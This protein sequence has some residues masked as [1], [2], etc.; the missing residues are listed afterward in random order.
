MTVVNNTNYLIFTLL[1]IA[2]CALH[3]AMIT[4]YFTQHV[5]QHLAHYSRYH[6]LF[7]NIVS[8]LTLVP[9]IFYQTTLTTEAIFDWRGIFR[10]PQLIFVSTGV[11]LFYLGMKKYDFKRFFGVSQ[12]SELTATKGITQSGGL[13]TTGILNV[14]RHPWYTGFILVLWARPIDTSNLI[15]NT[16]FTVICI[17]ERCSKKENSL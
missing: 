2:W 4:V 3:S 15:L 14:I 16:V 6:R 10:I 8:I 5:K 9:I 7:F 12:L 1:I 17:L 11:L 13:D